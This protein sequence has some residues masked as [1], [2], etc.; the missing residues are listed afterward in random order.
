MLKCDNPLARKFRTNLLANIQQVCHARRAPSIIRDT[1][2]S[3]ISAWMRQEIPDVTTLDPRLHRLHAVQQEIGWDLLVRGFFAKEWGNISS[4]YRPR[5][6]KPYNND[7]LF[8]KLLEDIWKHQTEFW[9]EYQQARHQT[10][11]DEVIVNSAVA[12]LEAKVRYLYSLADQVLPSQ[13]H[14]YF[15]DDVEQYLLTHHPTQLRTYVEA[16]ST[17]IR[18]SIRH[19]KRQARAHTRPLSTYGFHPQTTSHLSQHEVTDSQTTTRSITNDNTPSPPRRLPL[20]QRLLSWVNG[21]L[22]HTS[23]SPQLGVLPRTSLSPTQ[24]FP[25]G[26]SW[27]TTTASIPESQHSHTRASLHP[28][29]SRWRP[30]NEQREKFL[31]FF[32]R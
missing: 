3:W 13:R 5:N 32:R 22:R 21:R 2:T 8:P 6:S 28:K 14:R 27:R 12:E 19:A 11:G 26:Q 10:T 23:T 17:A 30:T 25:P 9:K 29:H 18:L 16:Y 1:L 15:C 24:H 31:N 4:Q 7:F 20:H